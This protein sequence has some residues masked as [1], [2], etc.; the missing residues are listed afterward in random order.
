MNVQLWWLEF[1]LEVLEQEMNVARPT[2]Q[3]EPALLDEYLPPV[4]RAGL[5]TPEGMMEILTAFVILHPPV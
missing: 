1:F 2:L 5:G 3:E 4:M